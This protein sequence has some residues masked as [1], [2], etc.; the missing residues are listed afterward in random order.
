[1]RETV[2]K[3]A[4][5]IAMAFVGVVVGA[6]FASGQEAIQ[7]FVAFGPWGIVGAVIA[8]VLISLVGMIVMRFGSYWMAQEHTAV[9]NRI[10]GPVTA[11]VLDAGVMAT[12]FSVGFVMF[13]GAGANLQQQF[14]WP[15]WVG[16]AIMIAL[17][18]AT[19]FLDIDK[20]STVIGACTPFIIVFIVIATVY[21]IT[22]APADLSTLEGATS[23]VQTGLP[24]WWVSSL[25]YVG[26]N[27]IV[28]ASMAIVIGGANVDTRAAGWG[29]LLGGLIFSAL[30]LCLVISLWLT[31]PVVGDEAMPTLALVNQIHPWLGVAMAIVI[32]AMIYNTAIGMFYSMSRRVT[33]NRP[34]L[35]RKVYIGFCLVGVVLSTVGFKDL[36]SVLYP[37]LGYVG[38]LLIAVLIVANLRMRGRINAEIER[39]ETI[40]S[41]LLRKLDPRKAF[42]R[43]HAHALR[44]AVAESPAES[45][46]L[47][48]NITGEV[49]EELV[50]DET[51]DFTAADAAQLQPK[52]PA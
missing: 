8:S 34:Q 11:K 30:V 18:I 5:S 49:V 25:N 17:T 6:G 43:K 31:L 13:A 48:E 7:F 38:L 50:A 35:F 36:V 14:G 15:V 12:L 37:I 46:V 40:R 45:T 27:L 21:A 51:V 33:A 29:G 28:G 9:L 39:R 1:M 41:L 52:A 23:R 32:Y 22:Q 24:N 4:I 26:F 42:T 19:G 10:A 20:V 3:R 2:F 47:S 16:S 44:R